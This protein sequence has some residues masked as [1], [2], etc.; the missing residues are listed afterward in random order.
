M[1]P[2]ERGRYGF[3]LIELIIVIVI[4]GILASISASAISFNTRKA[5]RTEAIT[6]MG[7][8]RT[9]ERLYFTEYGVYTSVGS[10]QWAE[11]PLRGY[12]TY[13][14]L[15]GRYFG[16]SSY[17]VGAE[18]AGYN[19]ICNTSAGAPLGCEDLVN[20]TMNESGYISVVEY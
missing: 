19:V 7:A 12:I 11:G 10:T 1:I 5:K 6:N 15:N 18:G 13:N 16:G 3:T 20:I 14:D 4:I 17:R 9:A 8:I 2:K